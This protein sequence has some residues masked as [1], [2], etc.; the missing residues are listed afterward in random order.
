MLAWLLIALAFALS[1]V[2][3]DDI[4]RE[5]AYRAELERFQRKLLERFRNGRLK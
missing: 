1:A 5:R 2:I 3:Y 4:Q